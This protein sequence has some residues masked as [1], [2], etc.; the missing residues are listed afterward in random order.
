VK[1]LLKFFCTLK[2]TFVDSYLG[3]IRCDIINL[4]RKVSKTIVAERKPVFGTRSAQGEQRH[5]WRLARV[6]NSG[7][8]VG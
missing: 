2:V 4:A 5:L 8:F 6:P 7:F 1:A 3:W